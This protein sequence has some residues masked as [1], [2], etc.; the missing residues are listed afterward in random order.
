MP[1]DGRRDD[2]GRLAASE[3]GQADQTEAQPSDEHSRHPRNAA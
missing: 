1:Y 3:D 2:E